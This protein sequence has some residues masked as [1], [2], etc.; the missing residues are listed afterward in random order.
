MLHFALT[1]FQRSKKVEAIG[2]NSTP[3]TV[4]PC[5]N[6]RILDCKLFIAAVSCEE[7]EDPSRNFSA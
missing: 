1:V 3:E 6:A 7:S 5:F 4:P 2:F